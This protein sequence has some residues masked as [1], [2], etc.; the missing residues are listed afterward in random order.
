M[1]GDIQE[2]LEVGGGGALQAPTSQSN[3]ITSRTLEHLTMLEDCCFSLPFSYILHS[4]STLAPIAFYSLCI[5]ETL[6]YHQI[7]G[8]KIL[9]ALPNTCSWGG[10][11]TEIPATNL[12]FQGCFLF[13]GV[14]FSVKRRSCLFGHNFSY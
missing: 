1:K 10:F 3:H 13:S 5:P 4:E 12:H 2:L 9:Q 8:W 6:E 11:S 14:E 7:F